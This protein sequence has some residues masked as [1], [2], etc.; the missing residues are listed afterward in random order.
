MP[1]SLR[2]VD[3][4]DHDLL[5]ALEESGDDE[6]WATSLEIAEHLGLNLEDS[7]AKN[8]GSRLAWLNRFGVME[9]DDEKSQMRWRINDVG[10]T[11]LHPNK[12]PP[13][14][15][16]ALEALDEGQRLMVTEAVSRQLR[17]TSRQGTHLAK[18]AFTHNIGYWRDASIAPKRNG[19]KK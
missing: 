11:L 2:L 1:M 18:R 6:G 17:R 4:S 12:L 15:M 13:S 19:K 10:F 8:I 5:Y 9:Q 3:F 14:A 16:K 7:P